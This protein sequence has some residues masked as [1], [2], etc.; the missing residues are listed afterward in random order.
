[1][2]HLS[3]CVEKLK[4]VMLQTSGKNKITYYVINA[5]FV[6]MKEK[7]REGKRRN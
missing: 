4:Y 3:F 7:E 5:N 1:M 6:M 2:V